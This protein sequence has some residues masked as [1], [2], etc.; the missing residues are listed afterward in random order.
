MTFS[1][2]ERNPE[3]VMDSNNASNININSS[4]S[5]AP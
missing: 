4:S 1:A 3:P 2:C 5:M